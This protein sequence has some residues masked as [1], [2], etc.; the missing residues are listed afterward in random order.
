MKRSRKD[1]LTGGSHDVNPQLITVRATMTAANTAISILQTIPIP[2]LPT[3]EGTNL[4]LELLG[5]EYFALD[6]QFTV[7]RNQMLA[8]LSTTSS[9]SPTI[10]QALQDPRSLSQFFRSMQ[11]FTAASGLDFKAQFYDDL[12]DGAGHGLLLA[13][14]QFY[15]Q[16][17]SVGQ[18]TADDYVLKIAY[19]WKIVSLVEYIGIVQSQQ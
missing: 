9:T 18:V 16:L 8:L 15:I 7:A 2:R 5:V 1:Q 17:Y 19:R 3:K 4:V 12:T 14:D 11:V 13:T 6:D 10:G